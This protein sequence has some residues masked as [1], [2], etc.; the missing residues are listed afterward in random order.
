MT[1]DLWK[2]PLRF[3]FTFLG[4]ICL[5]LTLLVL[6]A[7][8]TPHSLEDRIIRLIESR[9]I[10]DAF[11][12]IRIQRVHDRRVLCSVNAGKFFMPASSM[13]LVT[14]AA[15]L[16][17]LGSNYTFKTTV[18]T[19]GT[20]EGG[21]LKG[22]LVLKGAGDPHFSHRIWVADGKESWPEDC[23]EALTFLAEEVRKTGVQKVEG[24]LIVDDTLFLCEPLGPGWA[25]DDLE[26][27][28]AAPVQSIAVNGNSI[29]IQLKPS[30]VPGETP[31]L[32]I[33]P[34]LMENHFENRVQTV[35]RGA[36][37]T[38]SV[39]WLPG[40]GVW[41]LYGGIPAGSEVVSERLAVPDPAVY[42]GE[43]FK[44]ALVR[45]GISIKGEL[46]VHHI[47]PEDVAWEERTKVQPSAG[48]SLPARVIAAYPSLPLV[49]ILKYVTK[50]SDNL[51]AEMLSRQMGLGDRGHGS[52]RES[53]DSILEFLRKAGIKNVP[54]TAADGSGL[55]KE[56]LIS[57]EMLTQLLLYMKAHPA[58]GTFF[59]LLPVA[60]VDGTLRNRMTEAPTRGRIL[61]KTGTQTAVSSLSG[62]ATTLRGDELVF[63]I[64]VNNHPGRAH[65]VRETIDNICTLMVEYQGNRD[66]H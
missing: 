8:S 29:G 12:G 58:M 32:E 30:S 9:P 36:T 50:N 18:A 47:F 45:S 41:L 44:A 31:P 25:W 1:M 21:I 56:N 34:R 2:K 28:Y 6:A 39:K 61:A 19:K 49:E 37:A 5:F 27:Y 51:Y 62:V 65:E 63:A 52:R 23:P 17:R 15:V 46:R 66:S 40:K 4:L 11:W 24:D 20:L 64:M 59:S 13:K 26:W 3:F 10:N 42:A 55:S 33:A 38:F 54:E 35:S 22:A 16:D 53:R 57:P 7:P 14:A 43:L 48:P 60:G